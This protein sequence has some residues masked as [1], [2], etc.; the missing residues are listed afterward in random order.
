M[1]AKLNSFTLPSNVIAKMREKLRDTDR[2][3]NEYGFTFCRSPGTNILKDSSHCVGDECS[4]RLRRFCKPTDILVGDYHT[5]PIYGADPSFQDM[6]VAYELGLGCI[7]SS[8]NNKIKCYI[9]K[10]K[11]RDPFV[12]PSIKKIIKDY[13]EPLEKMTIGELLSGK[14]EELENKL[15]EALYHFRDRYFKTVDIS[16]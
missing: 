6:I 2:T 8:E 3:G 7:G 1:A 12:V 10:D 11:A 16:Q 13:E 4:I 9:R 15:T 5:H 14:G